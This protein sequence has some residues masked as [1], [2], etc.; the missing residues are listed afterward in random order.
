MFT[1]S[2]LG[3]SFISPALIPAMPAMKM[4]NYLLFT[5]FPSDFAS[6]K[7]DAN[8]HFQS[9]NLCVGRGSLK[10]FF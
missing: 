2:L 5:G 4:R 8:M 3:I 9:Q 10:G 6:T 7:A 1:E